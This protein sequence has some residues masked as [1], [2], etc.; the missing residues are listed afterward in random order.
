MVQYIL[1]A[2]LLEFWLAP[3]LSFGAARDASTWKQPAMISTIV[4]SVPGTKGETIKNGD[5]DRTPP[6]TLEERLEN[7]PS[8]ARCFAHCSSSMCWSILESLMGTTHG[9]EELGLWP[10]GLVCQ[11]SA[12]GRHIGFCLGYGH[13]WNI[14][15]SKGQ[16]K[17]SAR[18]ITL[19][20]DDILTNGCVSYYNTFKVLY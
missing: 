11:A 10:R 12:R 18:P 13:I 6:E 15:T 2:R 16:Q 8:Y 17:Y 1:V 4:A 3:R 20:H 7:T 9:A 19:S 5:A 14:Q